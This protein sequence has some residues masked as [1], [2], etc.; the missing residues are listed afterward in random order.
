MGKYFCP[1]CGYEGDELIC[2]H[3]NIPAEKLDINDEELTSQA[4]Y[5]EQSIKKIDGEEME[6]LDEDQTSGKRHTP[7][8][9]LMTE[10]DQAY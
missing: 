1:E 9:D 7:A 6:L 10:E 4:T 5:P 3:C 8:E 2:P